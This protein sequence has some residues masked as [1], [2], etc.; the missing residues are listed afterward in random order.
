MDAIFDLAQMVVNTRYENIPDSVKVA[1]KNHML[2]TLGCCLVGSALPECIQLV[3]QIQEWGG[4]GESTIMAFGDKVPAP[5]AALANGSFPRAPDYE[6]THDRGIVHCGGPVIAA[7]FAIAEKMGGVNGKDLIT[8]AVLG[9]DIMCRLSLACKRLVTKAGFSRSAFFGG[10]GAAAVAG[11]LLNLDHDKLVNAFGIAYQQASGSIQCVSD[12]AQSKSLHTGFAAQQG[13]VAAELAARGITGAR[14]S[15][16]GEFG[17]FNV[18]E[19]GDYDRDALVSEL[20]KRFEVVNLSFKPYT[21]CRLTHGAIDA[22]LE[23]VQRHDIKPNEIKGITVSTG[24]DGRLVSEP[25]E[26]K[27]RP[28]SMVDAQFS[29]PYLVAVAAVKRKVGIKDVAPESLGNPDVLRVAQLVKPQVDAGF[30]SLAISPTSVTIEIKDNSIYSERVDFPYGSPQRRMKKADMEN[31]F[32]DCANSAAKTI[33]D[34]ATE[35]LIQILRSLE[36]IQDVSSIV[37]LVS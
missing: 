2:D 29:I 25:L 18:Y 10:F 32:R 17:L 16:E 8:A 14:H 27:K 35:E 36:E 21:S 33:T 15:L 11:K 19:N 30:T 20:G 7:A 12:A 1:A 4:R 9:V 34:R 31:K 5:M 6:D 24:E 3:K 23:L 13:V 26:Q 37:A 28:A 22:T